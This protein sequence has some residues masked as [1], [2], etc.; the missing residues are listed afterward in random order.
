[1]LAEATGKHR[2][3]GVPGLFALT[4]GLPSS[5]TDEEKLAPI[6]TIGEAYCQQAQALIEA[7]VLYAHKCF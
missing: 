5:V 3:F 7:L 1:M 6:K 2:G 4:S